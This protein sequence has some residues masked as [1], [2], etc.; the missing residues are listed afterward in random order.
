MVEILAYAGKLSGHQDWVTSIATTFEQS[1]L[2]ITS[3]RDEKCVLWKLTPDDDDSAGYGL[4]LSGHDAAVQEVQ[5]SSDCKFAVSASW[6]CTMRL[7]DLH[8]AISVRTFEGHKREVYSVA[9]SADSRQIVSGGRDKT[10]KLWSC[11]AQCKH[12]IAKSHTGFVSQVAFCSSTN[13]FIVSCSSDKF[14][15][16]WNLHP[17]SLKLS[18]LGHTKAVYA[19]TVSPDFTL[20][21]S[22]GKD[23]SAKLWDLRDG[24]DRTHLY[25]LD[26]NG[27][28]NALAFSPVDYWLAAATDTSI[29]IW[30]LENKTVIDELISVA[31]RKKGVPWCISVAWSK[32]GNTLFCGATDGNI[33]LYRITRG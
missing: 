3:S 17:Y 15:K 14:V 28:V 11:G 12:T 5:I 1:D 25:A 4:A 2:V 24:K 21:A 16:A 10:I 20:C 30:D 19:I 7:W 29:L 31:P 13:P 33:Y 32:D 23:G 8:T 9:F 22:G 26:A 18:L 27:T 6:D